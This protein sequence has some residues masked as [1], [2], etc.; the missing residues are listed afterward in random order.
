M[1][2]AH[3]VQ[4][5]LKRLGTPAKAKTSAWFFKTGEGHYG[6]GDTFYGVTVPE[7]RR[8]AKQYK[9][10][11]LPEIAKLL[12]S[13]VHECRLTALLILVGQYQRASTKERARIAKFYLSHTKRVNNWDLVDLSASYI[14]GAELF[15][16][17]RNVLYK[18]ARSKNLW[19]RRI[20]I[21]STYAFIRCGDLGD[22]FRITEILMRDTHDLIHKAAGW[23]LREAGKRDERQLEWFLQ[24]HAP[25]MPRTM[26]RYAIEKFPE[27][28]RKAYLSIP[29]VV[30]KSASSL[31]SMRR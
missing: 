19:E 17:K 4:A 2:S 12:A 6:H 11:S 22:T 15:D 8:I 9:D 31:P 20:A 27:Q 13:P 18:F 10:V 26:L 21:V 24:K 7:Q 14:L 23:M 25:L 29:S 30:K 5:E 28:K 3:A 1:Q 16:K